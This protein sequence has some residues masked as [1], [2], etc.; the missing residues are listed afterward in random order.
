[1]FHSVPIAFLMPHG[2][3]VAWRVA[4]GARVLW[5]SAPLPPPCRTSDRIFQCEEILLPHPG[6]APHPLP[7]AVNCIHPSGGGIASPKRGSI[8]SLLPRGYS[9]PCVGVV[10]S[11]PGDA[12]SPSAI[13]YCTPIGGIAS[14]STRVLC[15]PLTWGGQ[16]APLDWGVAF[17]FCRGMYGD[18][19]HHFRRGM[20]SPRH[21]EHAAHLRRNPLAA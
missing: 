20:L 10:A 16:H 21:G 11:P 12:A 3:C 4:V 2:S 8:V 19:A 6:E 1:M 5:H 7:Y 18:I 15:T 13:G 9:I 17:P 14:L